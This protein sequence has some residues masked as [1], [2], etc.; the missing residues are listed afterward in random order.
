MNGTRRESQSALQRS[1]RIIYPLS[2]SFTS[3]R[4]RRRRRK[5]Y[6]AKSSTRA[7]AAEANQELVNSELTHTFLL[8]YALQTSPDKKNNSKIEKQQQQQQLRPPPLHSTASV[9]KIKRVK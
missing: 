6:N 3:R 7:A 8:S 4:R 2:A 1:Y 5:H 9:V